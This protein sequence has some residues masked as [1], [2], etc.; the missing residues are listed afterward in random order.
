MMDKW[1]VALR[2]VLA[3]FILYGIVHM[4]RLSYFLG[5]L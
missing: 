2:I 3:V 4:V 1:D 5:V